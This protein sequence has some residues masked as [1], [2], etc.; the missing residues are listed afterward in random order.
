MMS[1][2]R[3][4][5]ADHPDAPPKATT[6]AATAPG[7]QTPAANDGKADGPVELKDRNEG[8]ADTPVELK[9]EPKDLPKPAAADV[10]LAKE[11]ELNVSGQDFTAPFVRSPCASE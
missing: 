6:P 4:Q 3:S 11:L 8:K 5:Q 7:T 10:S 1:W 9:D 2:W